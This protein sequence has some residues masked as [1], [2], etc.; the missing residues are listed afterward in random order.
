MRVQVASIGSLFQGAVRR[1]RGAELV[2][3]TEC[4]HVPHDEVPAVESGFGIRRK[5]GL[6]AVMRRR[7][8]CAR[9]E[10]W[11]LL[12][13]VAD[14]SCNSGMSLTLT[15]PGMF[16]TI[17]SVIL[18][19]IRKSHHQRGTKRPRIWCSGERPSDLECRYR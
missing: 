16:R 8:G 19:P 9:V 14:P 2:A 4:R 15:I 12:G 13:L 5:E 18:V 3:A 1:E 10:E 7:R 6:A 17:D 11:W